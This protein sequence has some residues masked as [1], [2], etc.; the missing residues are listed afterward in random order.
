MR[1]NVNT[2]G[3]IVILDLLG[4]LVGDA[5][6][7]L[8]AKVKSLAEENAYF[9]INMANIGFINSSGLGACMKVQAMLA[10][11]GGLVAY[12]HLSDSVKRVFSVTKA[13][14]KLSIA[15]TKAAAL[16]VLKDKIRGKKAGMT[17]DQAADG[18]RITLGRDFKEIDSARAG[19]RVYCGSMFPG[20]EHCAAIDD[21]C[22]AVTEAMNN[23]V[24]HSGAPAI[25]VAVVATAEE[26]VFTM[27]TPGDKFDPTVKRSMPDLDGAADLPEGGFGLAIM[28]ALTDSVAY[29]YR[30][31]N[32]RLTLKKTI[33]AQKEEHNGN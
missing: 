14:Q 27:V 7:E 4:D 1:F 11:Q 6:N 3:N 28:Q 30:D 16:D 33:S 25:E 22:L 10:E 31:G 13:D 21:F 26:I 18:V 32:N 9:V 8:V 23:A 12:A 5:A 24:E 15:A 2:D 19:I 17:D 20:P 29:E